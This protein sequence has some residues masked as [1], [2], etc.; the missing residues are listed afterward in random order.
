LLIDSVFPSIRGLSEKD[1]EKL[2]FDYA[3]SFGDCEVSVDISAHHGLWELVG[4]RPKTNE[5]CGSFSGLKICDNVELHGRAHLDGEV[6]AG[7]VFYRKTYR[8]CHSPQCSVCCFSGWAK[9]EADKVAQR[10]EVASKHF[11]LPEHVIVSPS[12]SDWGLAEF[13]NGEYLAKVKKAMNDRGFVGGCSIFHGF[14]YAN[15]YESV[16]KGV[17][18]GWGWHPHVHCIAFLLGGYGKCRHCSKLGRASVAVCGSCDGFEAR[19]RRCYVDDKTV[20]KIA[21]DIAMHRRDER[22]TV[23]GT[24]WYQLNHSA[25]RVVS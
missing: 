21:E 2:Y 1:V 9:R 12:N 18:Y 16:S 23:F 4:Q 10:I 6:H 15:Y 19:T 5:F 3:E 22:I 13:H 24:A 8:S 20:V 11:G 25:I 7:E 14:S 17:L